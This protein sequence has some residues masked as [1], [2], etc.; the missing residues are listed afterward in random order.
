MNHASKETAGSDWYRDD[1]A[2]LEGLQTLRQPGNQLGGI[3]GYGDF[4]ELRR[5]GQ[6]VVYTATQISTRR[7]VAIKVLLDAGLATE[8][9]KRRFE[10]EVDLAAQLSHSLS[11]S[12]RFWNEVDFLLHT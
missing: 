8:Q 2:L 3:R 11:W 12:I 1:R 7:R 5:G 10:R 6:G 9:M 4:H